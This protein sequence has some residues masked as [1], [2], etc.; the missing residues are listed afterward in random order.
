MSKRAG[1]LWSRFSFSIKSKQDEIETILAPAEPLEDRFLLSAILP[2]FVDGE[3]SFGDPADEAPYGLENTFLLESNPNSTKTIF[4]DFD[5]HH[6]VNNAWGHDIIFP[7]FDRDGDSSTFSDAELIEIQRQFQV[8]V[9]DF[10]P[11]DVNVTTIDPGEDALINSGGNDQEWGIRSLATQATDGFGNGIGGVAFIGSFNWDEDAPAFTFNKGVRNGGMTHSHEIGHSLFLGHDGLNNQSYHPGSGTGSTAWGPIM[12]APFG[13]N[14]VHWSQ[15]EYDGSTNSQDDL[16]IITTRNGFGYRADDHGNSIANATE[17]SVQNDTEVSGWGIVERNTDLDV[18][19]FTTGQGEVDLTISPFAEN[20]NLD[21]LATLM[22]ADGNVIATSNPF[23]ELDARFNLTLDAGEYYISIDGTGLPGQYTDYGSLGF[24]SIVGD[25]Q[26]GTGE[27][28]FQ[29]GESGL[30]NINHVWE[31]VT[32]TR[33]YV[34]PV[35]IASVN[36]NFGSAQVTVRV[37][38]VTSNSFEIQIDEWDYLDGAHWRENVSYMVVESGIHTLDNGSQILAGNISTNHRSLHVDF[39]SSFSETPIVMSQTVT[40]N[41]GS[42]VTTRVDNVFASGFDIFL[43]EEEGND[44]THANEQISWIAFDPGLGSIVDLEYENA[45]TESTNVLTTV[46]INQAFND[47]P[48]FFASIQT[49]FDSDTATVRVTDVNRDTASFFIQEERSADKELV[50]SS[51]SVGYVAI[52]SGR[53]LGESRIGEAGTVSNLTDDWQVVTLSQ[54]YRNPVVVAGL[55]SFNDSDPSTIRV[56]NVTSNSFEIQV[57]EWD[58]LNRTH[59]AESV[60]YFVVEAGVHRLADGTTLVADVDQTNHKWSEFDFNGFEFDDTPVVLSQITSEEGQSSVAPRIDRVS[61]TGFRHLLQE[62]EFA[63]GTHANESFGWIAIETGFGESGNRSFES[64]LF[65]GV[66]DQNTTI[67]FN[68]TFSRTP[69]VVGNIQTYRDSNPATL[70]ETGIGA[71]NETVSVFI[72]EEASNDLETVHAVEQ[73]GLFAVESGRLPGF[74][75]TFFGDFGGTAIRQA[76][77]VSS[78]ASGMAIVPRVTYIDNGPEIEETWLPLDHD[79]EIAGAHDHGCCCASCMVIAEQFEAT[80]TPVLVDVGEIDQAPTSTDFAQIA[81]TDQ[82]PIPIVD[83]QPTTQFELE[84]SDVSSE[85]QVVDLSGSNVSTFEYPVNRV[86][87]SEA[88]VQR[89]E[90]K[91]VM[92]SIL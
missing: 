47:S 49:F 75:E 9:E 33:D 35:V 88:D 70:R 17:L 45:S 4:L 27:S 28:D 65:D 20:P 25:I 21:V 31:T 56:R 58:Y 85:L 53:I 73:V 60:S 48:L 7:A 66:D 19:S 82:A 18:F 89:D 40:R 6:S 2:V 23:D 84:I 14:I 36:S 71:S 62:Q 52:D 44:G 81:L 42:A 30:L 86:N 41:G 15:G 51:E 5:G 11:F 92:E 50:H 80:D 67:T 55:L 68:N 90:I 57:D 61:T 54:T 24:F 8:V 29:I 16:E 63:D 37:R 74:S 32:L 79:D 83:L 76:A 77:Q 3:F 91:S 13:H 46:D 59:A 26:A 78:V 72:E 64:L 69:V 43:Q 1:M 38:N 34:D 39:S 87:V 12:G 22:D 10:F